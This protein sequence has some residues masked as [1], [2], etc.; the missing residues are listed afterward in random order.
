MYILQ[1]VWDEDTSFALESYNNKNV[2]AGYL[3]SRL[4]IQKPC[5]INWIYRGASWGKIFILLLQSYFKSH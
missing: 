1:T 4:P 5:Q 2:M 3:I